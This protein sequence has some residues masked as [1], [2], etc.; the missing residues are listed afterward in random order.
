MNAFSSISGWRTRITGM[1]CTAAETRRILFWFYL[2]ALGKSPHP[3]KPC[4]LRGFS[5]LKVCDGRNISQPLTDPEAGF[6][7]ENIAAGFEVRRVRSEAPMGG[8]GVCE[9]I[10]FSGSLPPSSLRLL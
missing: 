2:V 8:S 7:G 4:F 3:C 1:V 6:L 10:G 9:W 5:A